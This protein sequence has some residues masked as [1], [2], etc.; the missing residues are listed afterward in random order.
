MKQKNNKNQK[1]FFYR[2]ILLLFVAGFTLNA[3]SQIT[4]GS[5]ILPMKAALLDIKSIGPA[6]P[7]GAT[8]NANGGGLLLPRVSLTAL[9]SFTPFSKAADE[10]LSDYKGLTIYNLKDDAAA[11]LAVG[12]YV[13]DGT[14]W[15]L[16]GGS[17]SRLKFFYM[18]S[19]NIPVVLDENDP[20]DL[21]QNYLDQFTG[22]LTAKN[23][24]LIASGQAASGADIAPTEINNGVV[25]ERN[26]LYYY[27]TYYDPTVM[28]DIT[29]DEN[30]VMSYKGLAAPTE[31]TFIN[32]V[33]VIR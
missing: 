24:N 2:V 20:F 26:E 22:G 3:N 23:I 31:N 9:D 32:V 13:W 12:I 18:P 10:D 8:T 14:K 7:G 25:F 1:S 4:I 5:E 19:I 6:A 17:D 27:V 16:A 11:Q 29:I 15:T 21:Y 33:F 28:G 30:G